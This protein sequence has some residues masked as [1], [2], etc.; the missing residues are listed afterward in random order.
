MAMLANPF[1][2]MLV[3]AG[4]MALALCAFPVFAQANPGAQAFQRMTGDM[5]RARKVQFCAY[6]AENAAAQASQSPDAAR[7]AARAAAAAK[8]TARLAPELARANARLSASDLAAIERE[9]A[10]IMGLLS[11]SPS[12]E[13]AAQMKAEGAGDLIG[14]FIT[15]AMGRCDVMIDKLGISRAPAGPAPA[16]AT[17]FRWD[18]QA[19]DEAFAAT[20]AAAFA[21]RLCRETPANAA[22]F[23]AVPWAERDG[24]AR[25]LLDWTIQCRDQAGFAALLE[26]GGLSA[27]GEA[28]LGL[29]A[30]TARMGEPW[31]L[32]ALLDKGASPDGGPDAAGFGGSVMAMLYDPLEPDGGEAYQRVRAAGADINLPDYEGSMWSAWSLHARWDEILANWGAFESDPVRLGRAVSVELERPG[33]A[34]GQPR[35]NRD[36]L[37]Q[38]KARL[39]AEHGVCF[40]VAGLKDLPKDARG[41]YTQ[42]DCPTLKR[43]SAA[44]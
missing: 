5:S 4:A 14:L 44:P 21:S 35:G 10:E 23:A 15:D 30:M 20:A 31:F 29:A 13:V 32:G 24:A 42:P 34:R 43:A 8:M 40:P 36:D 6:L 19:V 9:N 22:D 3:C 18:G 38:I 17:A 25:T 37:E 12:T 41:F 26:A 7:R 2:T 1:R 39:I 27:M 16:A 33:Q 11:Y 28:T